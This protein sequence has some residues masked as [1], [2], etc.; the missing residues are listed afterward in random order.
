VREEVAVPHPF[1]AAA[2]VLLLP[3]APPTLSERFRAEPPTHVLR[4]VRVADGA[5]VRSESANGGEDRAFPPGEAARFLT[6]LSGLE[7][8][9]LDPDRRIP[10][11]STCWG[12][13]SHGDPALLEALAT[14]CDTWFLRAAERVA[15]AAVADRAIALGFTRAPAAEGGWAASVRDWTDFWRAIASGRSEVEPAGAATL[16]AAAGLGVS[17]PRGLARP[18]HDPRLRVR[19]VA[20]SAPGGAWVTGLLRRGDDVDWAFALWVP[21]GT[22]PLAV[23]RASSLLEETLRRRENAA[24]E[25]GAPLSP[26]DEDR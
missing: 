1:L 25:R 4:I 19:A 24:A 16:L 26:L 9:A 17:S 5:T 12:A 22:V 21:D 18:L 14:G 3:G 20:G 23:T 6:A 11:D 7:T 10:C 8:G 15:A 2:L 13:G